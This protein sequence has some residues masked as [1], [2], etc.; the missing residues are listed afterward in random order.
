[1]CWSIPSLIAP[2]G[3]VGTVSSI[4]NCIG[5]V[6][7]IVAPMITGFTVDATGSFAPAFI[8]AGVVLVVG[9]IS[10]A[11]VLGS[12]DQIKLPSQPTPAT[13]PVPDGRG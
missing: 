1:M 2:T 11:Y 8:A 7:A 5:Q 10:F 3:A 6:G 9:I 12:L 13:E 4:M